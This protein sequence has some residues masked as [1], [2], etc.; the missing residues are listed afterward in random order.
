VKKLRSQISKRLNSFKFAIEGIIYVLSSQANMKIHFFAALLAI[1][2]AFLLHIPVTHLL[3]VLLVIGLVI[4]L[5]MV[6]TA[7]ERVV[8]LATE[9]YHP[10]AKTAKDV[11]AGAV[12]IAA[13]LALL[14]VQKEQLFLKRYPMLSNNQIKS[15][16][17]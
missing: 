12:L 7:I 13:F 15:L 10:F 3:I 6:N 8:D 9:E 16:R 17:R 2:L 14:V 1:L 4:C 11:A 5:E